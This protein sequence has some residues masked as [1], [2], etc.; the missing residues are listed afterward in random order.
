MA[1]IAEICRPVEAR[2]PSEFVAALKRALT[3]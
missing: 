1:V 3:Q 2:R